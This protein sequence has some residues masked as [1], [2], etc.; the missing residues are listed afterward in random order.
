METEEPGAV[1]PWC[2]TRRGGGLG[3]GEKGRCICRLI[4]GLPLSSEAFCF[5]LLHQLLEAFCILHNAMCDAFCVLGSAIGD[6]LRLSLMI[7]PFFHDPF[8][9]FESSTARWSLI[10]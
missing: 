3:R 4:F 1:P 8:S 10:Q 6:S 9:F 5:L 7:D 2:Q